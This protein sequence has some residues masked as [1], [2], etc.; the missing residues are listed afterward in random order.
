M[1]DSILIVDDESNVI[2]ALKR[3]M[4]DEP[5]D[6]YTANSAME[7]L[8]LMKEH[9][10]K[11][12]VSDERMPGMQGSEFLAIVKERYPKTIRIM[13]TGH[14]SLEA[15]MNAVNKGEIYRFFTKPWNDIDLQF[16]VKSALE[17]YNL[18]E[19]NRRLL[20]TVKSQAVEIK[21][22]EKHHPGITKLER[23]EQGQLVLPDISEQDFA[24][25]LSQINSEFK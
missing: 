10:V 25:I 9:G 18:E 6:V 22:L 16:A 8:D 2:S 23:D 5:F 3:L 15:A 21:V 11:V 20:E 17:K 24:D 13:L 19:E 14:A 1:S 4:V 12:V 7:G